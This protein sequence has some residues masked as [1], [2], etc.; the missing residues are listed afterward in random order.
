LEEKAEVAAAVVAHLNPMSYAA[1]ICVEDYGTT[2][3]LKDSPA[4]VVPPESHT[5]EKKARARH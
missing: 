2:G 3:E 1:S 5:P 4:G